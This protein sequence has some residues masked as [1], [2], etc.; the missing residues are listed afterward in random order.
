MTDA[1]PPPLT[2]DDIGEGDFVPSELVEQCR[3]MPTSRLTPEQVTEVSR[4]VAGYISSQRE[5]YALRA[6][7]LSAQQRAAVAAFFSPE[8]L[9]NTRVLALQGERVANPEFYPTLRGLG[10]K[11][12]PDQ[13][14]MAAITFCD[15]VVS[16]EPFS[17]GLLLHE[18]V[19]VEQYRQLGIQR[20][21]E[22]Y[23]RGFFDGRSYDAIPLEVNAYTLEDR[24]RRNARRGFSV[25]QEVAA[26]LVQGRL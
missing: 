11:D 14:A 22:L 9:S 23:V 13:S 1:A 8:L 7:P 5:T 2:Q 18:L 10:F 20:F 19:H 21:S 12:L 26:W 3:A 16:R 6:R 4:L 25:Q 24:F 17:D 15:L